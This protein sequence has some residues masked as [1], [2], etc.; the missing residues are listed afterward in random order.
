MIVFLLKLKQKHVQQEKKIK[1]KMRLKI[2]HLNLTSQIPIN[3]HEN[4]TR[5]QVAKENRYRWCQE[6]E[7]ASNVIYESK[8]HGIEELIISKIKRGKWEILR[9]SWISRCW[10]NSKWSCYWLEFSRSHIKEEQGISTTIERR[11]EN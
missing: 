10:S 5:E 1:D 2:P 8:D 3:D 11:E 4:I 9:N 7:K 6:N